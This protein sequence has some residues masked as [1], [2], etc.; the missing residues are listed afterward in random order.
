MVTYVVTRTIASETGVTKMARRVPPLT[1]SKIAKT[2]PLA[3][4]DTTLTDGDGL[5]LRI[6]PNG[7]KSWIFNYYHPISKKR[8]NISFGKYPEVTLAKARKLRSECR[9]LLA[10]DIDPK[11]YREEAKHERKTA[12]E[13]TFQVIAEQW[14]IKKETEVKATTAKKSWQLMEKHVLPFLGKMPVDTLKPK[15][16]IEIIKPIS[17]RGNHETVKRLCRHINEV[18]RVA[19]ASGLIDT[20]YFVDIT[21][22]FPAPKKKHMPTISPDRLPVLMQRLS[23][24][25]ISTNTRYLIE[26]Q[27]H[28]ITRPIEAASAKWSDINLKDKTWVIPAA[29]MKMGRDHV[30]P[31]S[32]PLLKLLSRLKEMNGHR[33]YVFPG[34]RD[35]LG[36][37]NSST[38]NVALKRMG[39]HG[40]L[41]AHGL[42]ALASTALNEQG[43]DSDLIETALAHIDRNATRRAYN[44]AEYVEQRRDMMEWWSSKIV[45]AANYNVSLAK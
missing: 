21:K 33:P 16:A 26:W 20:N 45:A 19:L 8:K 35:P 30:I 2:K 43:F 22:L 44:R 11:A 24:A 13:N 12:L 5:F 32:Q 7:S 18:M 36:H 39:F 28:T 25:H 31:L 37:L 41:V 14:I 10:S 6:K 1:D 27:L 42:R 34:H 3:D 17:A 23:N 9:E 29:Q 38:A 4:K 40:E 15:H